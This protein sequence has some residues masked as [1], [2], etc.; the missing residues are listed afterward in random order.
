MKFCSTC[1]ATVTRKVPEG[2]S[3]PRYVC[4]A[5]ATIHYQNPRMIVGCLPVWEDQ[6]LLCKRAIE[7]RHG[8]WTLPAGFMEN[9]ETLAAGAARETLEEANARVEIGTL[10][11]VYNV[12]H[13][14][15][16][17]LLFLAKLLDLNFSSG[18]ESLETRLFREDEIPWDQI[19][20]ATVRN[21]L[22]H[23]FADRS[24]QHYGFH[25]G[26]IERPPTR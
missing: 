23:Y 6:I 3:L 9:G 1:G 20:F 4:D 22:T 12:P 21:T 25:L 19:A 18:A 11:A 8:L 5:C 16:V 7:P 15:Q 13:V 26:T 17:Y 2:D 10:Y 24:R 14:N